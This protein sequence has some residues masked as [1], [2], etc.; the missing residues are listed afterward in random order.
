MRTLPGIEFL[1]ASSYPTEEQDIDRIAQ[2]L[3]LAGDAAKQRDNLLAAAARAS[4][5][6]LEASDVMAV[7]P[8]VLRLLGEAAEVDRTALALAEAGPDGE[9]YLVIRSEWVSHAALPSALSQ[10]KTD[11]FCPILKA[12]R[13]VYV[14]KG[15][16]ENSASI[17]SDS[18][19]SSVIVPFSVE[20]EYAGAV[21]F[22]DCSRTREFNPAVISA[23]EIAASVIGAALHRQHLMDTVRRERETAAEQRV[24]ELANANATLRSNLEKLASAC[25]LSDFL[26]YMLLEATRQIGA[27]AGSIVVNLAD[28]DT[29]YVK[30]NIR[31]GKVEDPPYPVSA[32]TD[33]F[34]WSKCVARPSTEP[35]HLAIDTLTS[36]QWPGVLEY[37]KREGHKSVYILPLVYGAQTIGFI[38]LA[39]RHHD[40]ILS[41]HSELLVAVAQQATLAIGLKRLAIS[42]KNAA[43]LAE[44]NRIGQEIHDGLAQAFTGILMQLGAVEETAMEPDVA[45]VVTR[46]RDIARE[47]LQEA[48]RSVLAL[49]P[50]EPRPGGLE[51]ALRQLAERSTLAGRVACVFQGGATPTGLAPEDEHELLRIAQE[52][53]SNALRHARPRTIV[54]ALTLGSEALVL[55][56]ADDGEG[57]DKRPELY[58]R[59]G[60]G[61]NNMRERAHA[62]GGSWAIESEPAKGTRVMVR[63]PRRAS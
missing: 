47:G 20:E 60:F 12:G 28:A 45:Q 29:W 58:A 17:T 51:L 27:A 49:K 16:A 55:S 33:E 22:D 15:M 56:I 8:D 52:A 1:M 54:I 36:L 57:M 26:C 7:M 43:V 18:A 35:V 23:L 42:A 14:C 10:R 62:I 44:R 4:R 6:L 13:S 63:I 38:M 9:R 48:R 40:P 31:D 11:C 41:Q 59:Q 34:T 25:D 19:Q 32:R 24:A 39:F 37:H 53:V 3:P 61:L 5:L 46:I 21:G 30:A 2:M 50:G